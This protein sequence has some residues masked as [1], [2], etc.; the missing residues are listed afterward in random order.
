MIN[1]HMDL[2]FSIAFILRAGY[3]STNHEPLVLGCLQYG[4]DWG[5]F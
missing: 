2:Q 4:C 5:G 3:Y 1:S